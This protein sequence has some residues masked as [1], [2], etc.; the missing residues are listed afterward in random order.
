MREPP[1]WQSPSRRRLRSTQH[2]L[3]QSL[4]GDTLPETSVP[5]ALNIVGGAQGVLMSVN[6]VQCVVGCGG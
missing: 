5:A 4:A 1:R 3:L 6:R 2:V